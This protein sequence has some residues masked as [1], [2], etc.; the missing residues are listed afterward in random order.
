MQRLG[1]ADLLV[2]PSVHE[3]G[4]GVVF[5]ALAMGAVPVVADFGGPG[6]IVNPEV[7]FKVLLT[8]END[9]VLQ[10]ER[11]L[12]KLARDSGYVR[13]CL[14]WDQKA[15][16]VTQVLRWAVGHGA[17]PDLQPPK[18]LCSQNRRPTF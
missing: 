8:N 14:S 2:F 16:I 12:A 5:E 4:G 6:D 1:A 18:A 15:Q 10:I 11:I 9:V 13:E 17:K 3:F 7:G